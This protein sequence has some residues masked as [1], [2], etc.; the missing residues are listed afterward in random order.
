MKSPRLIVL[1]LGLNLALFAG[2]LGYV[3]RARLAEPFRSAGS[4]APS[5]PLPLPKSLAKFLT[6][7][8]S[9][10]T[11]QLQWAQL[12]SEDYKTYVA[13]LRAIG[14]PEQTIRD[15]IIADLDKLMAPE[16]RS[17]SG[18]RKELKYWY[19][20]EEEMHNDVDP[21]EALR[22]EREIDK[23]KRQIIQELVQADLVSEHMKASGQEDYYE[24]RLQFLPE[25]TRAKVR[26]VLERFDEAE[27]QIREKD[28]AAEIGLSGGD[29]AQLRLL[30]QQRADDVENLLSPQQKHL[31][32]LWLSPLANDVRHAT[33]G[34]NASEQE[35]LTIYQAR[36]NFDETW[37]LRD[38]DLLDPASRQEMDQ[39]RAAMDNQI[40]TGLGEERFA[41]YQRGQ[42]DDFHLL[43]SL[44]TRFK[45]PKEKAAEVYGYKTVSL[46]YRSQ[47]GSNP[48]L[49][50]EQKQEASAAIA[51]ETRKAV[52]GVLG[53]KA[54]SHYVRSGQ[55]RWLSE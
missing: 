3:L 34:M 55:G 39:A 10:A 32:E 48:D 36:R 23:R 46:S 9:P 11:N 44:V 22:A 35:F 33:Y 15:I 17:A 28:E 38:P 47:I 26:E 4:D 18:R 29:R 51:E 14:C 25:A 7:P 24:R 53:N 16:I 27:Q 41:D 30:R 21:R 45:L 12:E 6:P 1:L 49:T 54:Y 50:E 20:E 52:R 8:P 42:D 13:R 5:Q 40:L 19:P 43:S 2:I 37:G 31:Y